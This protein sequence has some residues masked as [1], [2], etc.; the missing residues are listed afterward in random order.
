MEEQTYR[1][2]GKEVRPFCESA[3]VKCRGYSMRL[4][5]AGV[6]FGADESC[7]K[8]AQ[9]FK[10]HYGIEVPVSAIR[11][12]IYRHGAAM[13]EARDLEMESSLPT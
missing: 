2:G 4:Q 1:E 5:R 8:S 13:A 6:D 3:G 12:M 10:E 7:E 11:E 9:K